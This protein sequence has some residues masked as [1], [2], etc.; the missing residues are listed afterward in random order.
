MTV[1]DLNGNTYITDGTVTIQVKATVEYVE[2]NIKEFET[3]IENLKGA[4]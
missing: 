3:K 1:Y 2:N 4:I